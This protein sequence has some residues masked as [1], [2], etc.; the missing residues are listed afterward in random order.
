MKICRT[1]I[2]DDHPVYRLGLA[3]FLS[4]FPPVEVLK[5]VENGLQLLHFIDQYEFELLILDLDMPEQ[6]G[7]EFLRH[8]KN[9]TY[10]FKILVITKHSESSIVKEVLSSGVDGYLLKGA[11]LTELTC[12]V[13]A[14]LNDQ[15]FFSDQIKIAVSSNNTALQDFFKHYELTKREKQIIVL[16]AETYTDVEIGEQLGISDQTV[17]VHRKN[18]MQKIGVSTTRDLVRLIHKNRFNNKRTTRPLMS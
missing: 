7:I 8:I 1:V 10:S 2:A 17:N 13:Q 18:M 16:V 11:D 6:T 4:K 15:T 14:L 12:A 9:R 5:E 3:K